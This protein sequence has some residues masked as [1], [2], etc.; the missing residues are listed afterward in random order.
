MKSYFDTQVYDQAIANPQSIFTFSNARFTILTERMLRIEYHPDGNFDD[1]PTQVFWYRRQPVPSMQVKYSSHHLSL[2]TTHF[3]LEYRFSPKGLNDTN[4]QIMVKENHTTYHYGDTNDGLLPGT[5]RTLDKTNGP[6]HLQRGILSRRGWSLID[7]SN[8]LAFNKDGWIT[9]RD[10]GESYQDTYFLAYGSDYKHALLDYLRIAG[11]VP[12]VPRF[13]LGNWWSRFWEYSQHDVQALVDKFRALHIPLSVFVLDMDWH[14]TETGNGSSGWTGF[15]WNR[16]LF[17]N[18]PAML[19]WLHGQGLAV[20]LNLHPAAGIYPHEAPYQTMAERLAIDPSTAEV[21]PFDAADSNFMTAYFDLLLHPLED[22]GVDF[23]WLDWQQGKNTQIRNLDPLW[24]LNH[25]HFFDLSSR[26][27]KRPIIFS[28]WGGY[29]N[30]R[31]PIGFSGD[32]VISWDSLAFQP[33]FTASAA[34]AAYGWWSHDIGGHMRGMENSELYIRWLQFGLLS[35]ILRIHSGKDIFIDH[36]PWAFGAETLRLATAILQQRHAFIPY[37]YSMARRYNSQALPI[38]TPLYYDHPQQEA[39]YI[40]GHQYMFGSELMAIPIT[41]PADAQ[42]GMS[43]STIWFP[44]GEWFN[45]WD[46]THFCG[47]EWH[48]CYT[49]LEDIPLYA[50]A[51]AIV[52]LQERRGWG[53]IANPQEIELLVFPGADGSFELYEDDGVTTDYQNGK[54]AL[55]RIHSH[56]TNDHLTITI[57]P[58]SENSNLIP[59]KR[60]Y[61][62][63]V[64]GIAAPS[65]YNACMDQEEIKTTGTYSI[66]NSTFSFDAI[67]LSCNHRLTV[68]LSHKESS[69]HKESPIQKV[70]FKL[71]KASRMKTMTKSKIYAAFPEFSRDIKKLAE[72]RSSIS[73]KQFTA[74]L[75]TISGAGYSV[76]TTPEK[77]RYLIL[78]NPEDHPGFQY[79]LPAFSTPKKVPDEG[80]VLPISSSKTNAVNLDLLDLLNKKID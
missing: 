33:Y 72:V 27:K 43:R 8:S 58:V 44:P 75:E 9:P 61:R 7:D 14:I 16:K 26:N 28:R 5:I 77:Q 78:A 70:L 46:G 24:W 39:A 53:G 34:N 11:N 18:P 37:L 71:L 62:I 56:Y 51:G 29:G 47:P 35:P 79:Q 22:Q 3:S 20:T 45:F 6:V 17:P 41:A 32:T 60:S 30:H 65:S 64:R 2:N 73:E 31:Y 21:I 15:S 63:K 23:W 80:I 52:P 59:D 38:C 69:I 42:V 12:M 68:A 1:R 55:T 50:K 48:I 4:L 74:L 19:Q 36:Q 66:E 25:L 54:F 76:F 57:D 13:M 67:P 49:A 40:T 10:M